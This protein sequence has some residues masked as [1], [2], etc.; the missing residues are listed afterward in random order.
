VD[1]PVEWRLA[2]IG[3]VALVL[4]AVGWRLRESRRAYAM[5]LQGGAIAVLYLT[6][7]AAFRFYGVIALL[8]AFA[9]MVVVAALA[10][11]LAVR[12]DAL[13]LAV[14]GALGGFATPLLL[15]TGSGQHVPLFSYYLVLDLGIAAIAWY[16]HWR[17][18]NALGFICTSG[19][20]IAWG[21]RSYRPEFATSAEAFL[22]AFFLLFLAITLM[23]ARHQAPAD[24]TA[25]WIH[26]GLLFGLPTVSFILQH[27][28]VRGDDMSLALTA[29]AMGG[30][31]VG[32]AVLARGRSALA[33]VFEPA[34]AIGTVFL[35]L[36]IPFAFDAHVTAG[37]WSLEGAGLLWAG[38]RQRHLRT[39]MAG[40]ALLLLA[41]LAVGCAHRSGAMPGHWFNA[42]LVNALLIGGASLLGAWF[43]RRHADALDDNE[44]P[45]E[46]LMIGW[47]SLWLVGIAFFEV[48]QFAPRDR[49]LSL[50]IAAT[51]AIAALYLGLARRFAW[52]TVALFVAAHAPWLGVCLAAS[53]AN[54]AAPLQQ[55]GW[56]AWPLAL[57][58]HAGTLA[59]AAP[60]WPAPLR[61]MA[62]TIGPLLLG[63][64]GALQLRH[65]TAD[66]GD[67]WSA[68]PWLG[69]L[70]APALLLGLL[71]WEQR[72]PAENRHW[73]VKAEP[74]AYEL[75]ASGVLS[76]ALVGWAMIANVASDGT[77]RPLPHLPML[78]PLDLGIGLALVAAWA[79]WRS[80]GARPLTS[81][82]EKAGLWAFGA[83]AFAW[84]NGILVRAFHHYGGVPYRVDRWLDSLAVQS[85]LALLWT[86]VAMGLMWWSARQGRRAPWAVGAGLL[87]VVVLKLL[88][89]DLS[90]SGT[91]TRIV[92][93]IGVGA[94][95]LVIGYVA[96]L[97]A[98]ES[99][100]A[101]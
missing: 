13:A 53:A 24:R 72:R 68:W 57:L 26:A 74:M 101:T 38:L 33:A 14:V 39:R 47:A 70:V 85:G 45:A 34:L 6:L 52:P 78:N 17:V 12:Q 88:L 4:L 3:A 63:T 43:V 1:V 9:L 76:A 60:A 84:L 65:V 23:P 31:Y 66:W 69:W 55:G 37:A 75:I 7:F 46:V 22:I 80:S 41:G 95:M 44:R 71:L 27:G 48:V 58:V 32:I 28:I 87:G 51:S 25:R 92:S 54:Q 19:V 11:A 61:R 56:W 18:L 89:V 30:V 73:P 82:H 21:M 2:G 96:P 83:A 59:T 93:F 29:L 8:P 91:V 20:A 36:A 42:T 40:Y 15:S 67:G 94:L 10:A 16:R 100:R 62:H 97:P 50:L 49:A 90:G 86:V 77:A 98:K 79:W 64:L 5:V 99:D 81:A 35:T